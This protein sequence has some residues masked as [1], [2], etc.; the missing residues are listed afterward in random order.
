M[1]PRSKERSAAVLLSMLL[2]GT[3]VVPLGAAAENIPPGAIGA[4]TAGSVTTFYYDTKVSGGMTAMWNDAVSTASATVILYADWN[5]QNGTR[6]V[7]EG[8]GM[9]SDGVICVPSGHE[10]TI[11]LNGFSIDRQLELAIEDGEV[12]YVENGATLNLTDTRA[13]SGSAGKVTGGF[14]TN[15][16][17]GI[18]VAQGGTMNLWGGCITG[19]RTQDGGG[20]IRISGE[21]SKLTM[22]GGSIRENSAVLGGGGIASTDAQVEI[23]EGALTGNTT[24]GMG[25]G[26]FQSGGSVKLNSGSI[27]SNSAKNGGGIF[28][29]AAADLSVRG[30]F[31]V[32]NNIAKSGGYL[33]AGGG[34]FA[35]SSLP[36]R[37]S[38]TPSITGNRHSDGTVS[39]LT[40]WVDTVTPFVGPRIVDEGV[41]SGAK[42]GLNFS[43][44]EDAGIREL[45]FAPSWTTNP[46]TADG[47]FEYL[48]ADG[49]L[50]L[51]RPVQTSDY[52]PYILIGCGAVVLIA[53]GA[54]VWILV[55]ARKKNRRRKYSRKSPKTSAK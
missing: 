39:N 21:D 44:D 22:T 9:A 42:V 40:F 51:K 45:G 34:I 25:G 32:E 55:K 12:I 11:D 35:M 15:S 46:F 37:L 54:I 41:R 29:Q 50:Y 5:A 36:V 52:L 17:G 1:N 14:S 33:G 24:E 53:A 2:A 20:G 10:V 49:V 8:K 7:S 31:A 26:I 38:G 3:A 23:V 48:E 13:S 4:V 19:N 6:L 47:E 27:S 28:T 30:S 18:E 43:C 16:A